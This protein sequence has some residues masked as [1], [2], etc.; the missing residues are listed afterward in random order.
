MES[1]GSCVKKKKNKE[2]NNKKNDPNY[3]KPKHQGSTQKLTPRY[4]QYLSQVSQVNSF[5]CTYSLVCFDSSSL[6]SMA[7]LVAVNAL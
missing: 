4:G 6:C 1:Y 3:I 5:T 7:V 2:N